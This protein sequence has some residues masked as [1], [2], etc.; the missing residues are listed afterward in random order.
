MQLEKYGWGNWLTFFWRKVVNIKP[1]KPVI[2]FTEVKRKAS[3]QNQLPSLS[4]NT[5]RVRQMASQLGLKLTI[6]GKKQ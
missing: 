3:Q 2:K 4:I 5:V 6:E 1:V